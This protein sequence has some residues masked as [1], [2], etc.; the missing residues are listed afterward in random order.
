MS[1]DARGRRAAGSLLQATE[2]LGPAPD[3]D[4]LRRRHRRRSVGRAGLAFAAVIVAGALAGQALP[5]LESITPDPAPP[6][7]GPATT[8]AWPGVPGLDR[9]VRDAVDTGTAMVSEVAAGLSGV[10]VLNH[11][12]GRPDE[13][14]RVDPGT[15]RVVARIDV[16]YSSGDPA[17]GEDGSVWLVRP[18]DGRPDRPELLRVGPRTDRV[19][20]T[21][22]LPIAVRPYSVNR[23]VAAGG[24]VWVAYTRRL[25]RVDPASGSV[26]EVKEGGQSL[27]V[28][29]L[30]F[31]GGWLWAARGLEL[32][33]IDPREGTVKATVSDRDLHAAMPAD[34]LAAGAGGL[35][36]HGFGAA[37]EQLFRVDAISGQM[38]ADVILGQRTG[39][40]TALLAAGDRVVAVRS[41]DN[42]FLV[43]P[44]ADSIRATVPV[45]AMRAGGLAVGAGAVWIGDP[46]RGRLLRVDPA[47]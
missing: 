26:T 30:A 31:A 1:V 42:L 16:G 35:W 32:R 15:D 22:A 44:A 40:A 10:W 36:L 6:A 24:A 25:V 34:A 19:T 7:A 12:N 23:V 2:R 29:H 3:L 18:R 17:V 43:D 39:G 9:H 33:R 13:L 38:E 8:R 41:G 45:P 4:R 37:G 20:A 5:G 11:T 21:I 14:V 46:A 28:D 47:A 27:A